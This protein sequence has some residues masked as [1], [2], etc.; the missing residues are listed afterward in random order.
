MY[1]IFQR[2][3]RGKEFLELIAKAPPA[4]Q[5]ILSANHLEV[6]KWRLDTMQEEGLWRPLWDITSKL[7]TDPSTLT[8]WR[9][10]SAMLAA[11]D[12]F[13][14]EEYAVPSTYI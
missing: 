9:V 11:S 1:Q 5:S 8:D 12:H 6:L 2:Q 7:A 13:E 14:S 4:I 10:W 3:N